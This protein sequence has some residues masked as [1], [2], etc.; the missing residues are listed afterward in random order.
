[1]AGAASA[2]ATGATGATMT[3]WYTWCSDASGTATSEIWV[4]W[5]RETES[6]YI[7]TTNTWKHWCDTTTTNATYRVVE[8]P[9]LTAEQFAAQLES[10]RRREEEHRRNLERERRLRKAAEARA[11]ELLRTLLD[12]EQ[13]AEYDRAKRFY[14]V[15]RSGKRY[16]IDT[17]RKMHN[18]FE[19]DPAGK[20][21]EE[22]CIYADD[23]LPLPDNIAAQLLLL[24]ANENEFRRIAN[25][26]MLAG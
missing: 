25:Q 16:E 9:P 15:S 14:V 11:E 21:I 6:G 5:C 19:V 7:T 8:L 23:D 26:R 17:K 4:P 2:I 20:R 10:V 22:H 13:R 1:M 24:R 3:I 18:I 12:A